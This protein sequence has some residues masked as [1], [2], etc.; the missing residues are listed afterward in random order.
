MEKI[1]DKSMI[2]TKDGELIVFE[3]KD[4]CDKF[5]EKMDHD[6]MVMWF[7]DADE[8]KDELMKAGENAKLVEDLGGQKEV[9]RLA[10][11]NW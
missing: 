5:T 7:M 3:D 2:V 11:N 4:E 1:E 9:E 6:D 8:L 10:K